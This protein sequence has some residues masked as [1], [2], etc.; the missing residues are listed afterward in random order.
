MNRFKRAI[1]PAVLLA[2][3]CAPVADAPAASRTAMADGDAA[4]VR[5][6]VSRAWRGHIDA[7]IRKDL[8]AVLDIYAEDI[9]YIVEGSPE[10]RGR[11][12]IAAMEARTLADYDVV[13]AEHTIDALRVFGDV[14]YELGTVIGP[15]RPQDGEPQTVI[16]HFM[17]M[18]RRQADGA[19][20][21]A[22]IAGGPTGE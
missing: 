8:G 22:H 18:W 19:W 1:A 15:I 20:R 21:I 13:S 3:F 14:A 2:A 11:E 5:D 10:V 6:A 9:V 12:A 17:A 7:A 16:F 4:V